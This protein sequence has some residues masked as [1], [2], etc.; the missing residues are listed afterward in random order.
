[1]T[2]IQVNVP[3]CPDCGRR[4]RHNQVIESYTCDCGSKFKVVGE[5]QTER[6]LI[7]ERVD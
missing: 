1:M 2:V 4:L 3:I 5:G 6:E 7:C